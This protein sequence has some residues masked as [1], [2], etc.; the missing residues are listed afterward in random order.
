MVEI[1]KRPITTLF[2]TNK[3]IA[4]IYTAI[5]SATLGI[6]VTIFL[7]KYIFPLFFDKKDDEKKSKYTLIL[8]I[9]VLFGILGICS[10]VGRNFVQMI[11]YP[12][13]SLGNFEYLRL[14][15]VQSG[16][17]F[18]ITVVLFNNTIQ[19]KIRILKTKL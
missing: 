7:D 4:I 12:L 15:E 5:I 18:S 1:K 14:K 19:D 11:P 2:V 6:F 13:E 9:S 17:M 8:E 10:Y 3:F 16:A